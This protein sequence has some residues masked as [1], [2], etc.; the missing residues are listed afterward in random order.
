MS[1]SSGVLHILSMCAA[2]PRTFFFPVPMISMV[3]SGL[4]STLQLMVVSAKS[5]M[6]C[7]T[8][9]PPLPMIMPR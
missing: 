8:F 7:L 4:P 2:H 6:S 9:F 1:P 5:E 3:P